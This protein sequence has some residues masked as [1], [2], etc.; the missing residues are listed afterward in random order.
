MHGSFSRLFASAG[1][2]GRS[3]RSGRSGGRVGSCCGGGNFCSVFDA[4]F[5]CSGTFCLLVH[6]PLNASM[7]VFGLCWQGNESGGGRVVRLSSCVDRFAKL[8]NIGA[9]SSFLVGNFG[10]PTC[11]KR[12]VCFCVS[13]VSVITDRLST[14]GRHCLFV[15]LSG[16]VVRSR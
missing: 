10:F 11:E 2:G 5:A 4:L 1:L 14:G 3:G 8:G 15:D 13:F 16:R 9:R 7:A 6:V 12:L